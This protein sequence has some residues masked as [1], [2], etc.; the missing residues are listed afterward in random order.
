MNSNSSVTVVADATT[1]AVINQSEN[2]PEYGYIRVQQAVNQ[3]DDNGFLRRKKLAAIIAAPMGDLQ[4][5]GYYAGQLLPGRIIVQESTTPWNKDNPERDLKIAGKTGIVCRI[6][7][8]PIYRR[9][10]YT[11][12]DNVKDVFLAHDNVDELRAAYNES[13]SAVKANEDFSIQ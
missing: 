5:A 9:T 7:G 6:E 11:E 4:D 10:L 2:N 12:K 8:Q 13:S 3:Y 1:G